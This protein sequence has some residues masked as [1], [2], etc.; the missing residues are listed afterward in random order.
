M[1]FSLW[2]GIILLYVYNF[3]KSNDLD[4]NIFNVDVV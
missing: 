4:N 3:M 1:I 2:F